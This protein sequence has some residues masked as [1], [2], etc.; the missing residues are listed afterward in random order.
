MNYTPSHSSPKNE[1][2]QEIVDLRSD[3]VTRPSRAML[4]YM[5]KAKVGDDVYGDDP[6]VNELQEKVANL[7]SK[8]AGL[9]VSSGTQSNFCAILSHCQRGEELLTGDSYHVFCDEAGGASVLGSI[10]MGPL[11]TNSD[12]SISVKE[13][14]KAKKP[15]DSHCPITKLLSLENTVQGK[16]QSLEQ[17]N[18]CAAVAKRLGLSVH[19]DGARLMNASVKLNIP[20]K[21][22]V[23]KVDS[24]SLCLSKGLGAPVGSVLVGSKEFIKRAHRIRKL[25]GG[26]LRQSGFLASAG[27]FALEN[28]V[29]RLVADHKNAIYLAERLAEIPQLKVNPLEVQTNMVF[30]SIANRILPKLKKYLLNHGIF[31]NADFTPVRLVTHLDLDTRKI[32]RFVCTLQSFFSR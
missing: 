25:A 14:M 12:G 16:V 28:N 21:E 1:L 29:E 3:T 18:N 13:I 6:S 17:I 7:L 11:K 24:V 32:D 27:L 4:A 9:F 26:G 15:D 31:I 5:S 10:M 30:F 2:L 23:S 8:E 20:A 19:M 22:I